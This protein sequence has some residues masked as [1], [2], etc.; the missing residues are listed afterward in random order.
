MTI[1]QKMGLRAPPQIEAHAELTAGR[2]DWALVGGSSAL[3]RPNHTLAFARLGMLSPTGACR[4]FDAAADGYARAE[5]VAVVVLRRCCAG[6]PIPGP[7]NDPMPGATWA[8]RRPYA[9]VLGAGVNNDGHTRE[10]ITF[11]SAAAQ[12]A[13]ARRVCATAGVAPGDVCYVE[14]HGTGTAAG[15]AQVQAWRGRGC[16][17]KFECKDAQSC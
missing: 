5:G 14:A 13:L 7:T 3:L 4:S 15:D 17:A 2:L 8:A 16:V 6:A 11:P 9:R 1:K 10:G 12:R